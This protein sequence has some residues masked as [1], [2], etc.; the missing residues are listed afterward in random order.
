MS[1]Q[2][3]NVLKNYCDGTECGLEMAL[4]P[5]SERRH[6]ITI[7]FNLESSV[8]QGRLLDV[9]EGKRDSWWIL[10]E[11]QV[12][13]SRYHSQYVSLDLQLEN[14]T[15]FLTNTVASKLFRGLSNPELSSLTSIINL[16]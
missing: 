12:R 7:D 10:C 14:N 13:T 4:R 15:A 1:T 16:G 9:V 3:L 5:A 8:L 2:V 6:N 11:G